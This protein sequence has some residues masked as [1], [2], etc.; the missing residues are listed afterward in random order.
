MEGLL[1]PSDT[2]CRV[3]EY[4]GA[5]LIVTWDVRALMPRWTGALELD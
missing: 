3:S 4:Y 2:Q 1:Q 5:L